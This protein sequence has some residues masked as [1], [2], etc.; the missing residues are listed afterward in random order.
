MGEAL[1]GLVTESVFNKAVSM[2]TEQVTG[3]LAIR[4]NLETL[5]EDLQLIQALLADAEYKSSCS[6]LFHLWQERLKK[7][8]PDADILLDK[9]SYEILRKKIQRGTKEKGK[10]TIAKLVFRDDKVTKHFEKRI[11]TCVTEDSNVEKILKDMC[12]NFFLNARA[13]QVLL[14]GFVVAIQKTAHMQ[15]E[16]ALGLPKSGLN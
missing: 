15:S 13:P 8:A 5:A 10:T 7:A 11:W 6:G 3:T 9:F 4:D 14:V 2:T 16:T 1:L 12:T